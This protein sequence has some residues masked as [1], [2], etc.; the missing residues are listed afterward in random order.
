MYITREEAESIAHNKALDAA[1]A[2]LY[3][4]SALF[5]ALAAQPEIDERKFATDLVDHLRRVGN[6]VNPNNDIVKLMLELL[7][8]GVVS[9][10]TNAIG[11]H[12]G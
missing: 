2:S 6:D 11:R 9:G 5:N 8:N 12:K 10:F 1:A 4:T 3:I 7:S